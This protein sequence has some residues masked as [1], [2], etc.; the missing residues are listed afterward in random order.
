MPPYRE[1]PLMCL[2]FTY[3]T[4]FTDDKGKD[5]KEICAN[6]DGWFNLWKSPQGIV[7][8]EATKKKQRVGLYYFD[9]DKTEDY[10]SVEK[11]RSKINFSRTSGFYNLFDYTYLRTHMVNG[12]DN[13]DEEFSIIY[14]K[15]EKELLKIKN[16]F[17]KSPNIFALCETVEDEDI[18]DE[19]DINNIYVIGKDI[20]HYCRCSERNDFYATQ[21]DRKLTDTINVC[22]VLCDT[23]ATPLSHNDIARINI[24]NK[25]T[26]KNLNYKDKNVSCVS[27][28]LKWDVVI[29]RAHRS[30]L[31]MVQII[32]D[33]VSAG[34]MVFV[35]EWFDIKL[36]LLNGLR[37]N[38]LIL[39]M[40]LSIIRVFLGIRFV[41]IL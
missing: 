31:E 41:I 22:S 8:W 4:V 17:C 27:M 34:C 36:G 38:P 12:W 5:F 33:A 14:C 7:P 40:L 19:I 16:N 32:C 2:Y 13:N 20:P 24:P 1:V 6:L 23:V 10:L 35:P 28:F 37:R 9:K 21:C 26:L 39:I 18:I 11:F 30:S 3:S 25:F 29:V 15:N